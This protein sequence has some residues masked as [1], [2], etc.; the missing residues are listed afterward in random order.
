MLWHD[1]A[2]V[3][4]SSLLGRNEVPQETRHPQ[5]STASLISASSCR[6]TA[7]SFSFSNQRRVTDSAVLA[8]PGDT[9]SELDDYSYSLFR[10]NYD[11]S[12]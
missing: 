9:A 2:L 8:K 4:Q 3:I 12:F 7:P 10:F 6:L 1:W 5:S 11:S